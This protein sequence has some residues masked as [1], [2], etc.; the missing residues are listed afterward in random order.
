MEQRRRMNG[1]KDMY[2]YDFVADI[3]RYVCFCANITKFN[4]LMFVYCETKVFTLQDTRSN[5]FI[6]QMIDNESLLT[7]VKYLNYKLHNF[8]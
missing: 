4:E 3:C 1:E 2:K 5:S 8:N 6:E 7:T